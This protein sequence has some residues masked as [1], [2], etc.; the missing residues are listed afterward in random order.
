[1]PK[2]KTTNGLTGIARVI[3]ALSIV[4]S[5]I[6]AIGFVLRKMSFDP[7]SRVEMNHLNI[8]LK[9]GQTETQVQ[10]VFKSGKYQKLKLNGSSTRVSTPSEVGEG[11]WVLYI[12]YNAQNRV[13]SLK[14]RT[15]DSIYERPREP[16][17][18]DKVAP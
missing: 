4:I 14:L 16:A 8:R 10:N 7:Q 1:M 12:G 13:S 3:L 2:N 6:W 17:P 11:N 5:T 15:I 18:A 9:L